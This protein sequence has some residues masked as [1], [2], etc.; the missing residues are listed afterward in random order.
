VTSAQTA[1]RAAIWTNLWLVY[2]IWGSTYLGMALAVETAPAMWSMGV[3]VV[4]AGAL[5]ALVLR[6]TR[7]PGALRVSLR[8][9]VGG[10]LL[11]AMMLTGGIGAIALAER[12]VPIGVAA[13]LVASAAMWGVFLRTATG[14]APHALTWLGIGLGL[15]GIVLLVQPAG[16]GFDSRQIM[17][18]LL[19]VLGQFLWALG[20]F[21]TPRVTVPRDPLVLVVYEMGLGGL[22]FFVWSLLLREQV[23]LA[24]ISTR[25]W[26]GIGYL[27]TAGIVGYAAFTWLLAHVP[28]SLAQTNVYVNPVVAALLGLVVLGQSITWALVV[29]GVVCLGGVAL[30]IAGERRARAPAQDHP[31][32]SR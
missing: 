29:G 15:L 23:D 1:S 3:R 22:A 11:G 27:A 7:G 2:I 19:I 20:S 31:R 17:W 26:I 30:I 18:S 32:S 12:Y 24:T 4:V 6:I 9:A 14:D 21:L 5:L 25:S 28:L 16:S 10:S 8:E 13:L